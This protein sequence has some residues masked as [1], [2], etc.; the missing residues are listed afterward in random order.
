MINAPISK[1]QTKGFAISPKSVTNAYCKALVS[2]KLFS[3]VPQHEESVLQ[4]L[5]SSFCGIEIEEEKVLGAFTA[6]KA[7]LLAISSLSKRFVRIPATIAMIIEVM[8]R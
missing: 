2:Q 4:Q 8:T 3:S 7:G 5:V 6:E 1:P